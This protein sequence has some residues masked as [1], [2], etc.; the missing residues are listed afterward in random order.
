MQIFFGYFFSFYYFFLLN[1]NFMHFANLKIYFQIKFNVIPI[2]SA[3]LSK[4]RSEGFVHSSVVVKA[5]NRFS[6]HFN[7]IVNRYSII[8]TFKCL[9]LN[10]T[11]SLRCVKYICGFHRHV[12]FKPLFFFLVATRYI[13]LTFL[14][15]S[16]QMA[17][18]F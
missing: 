16:S 6:K 18:D 12:L 5:G 3:N 7:T 17:V 13:H 14:S 8:K 1:F 4:F 15:T 9:P 10:R 2:K 11:C